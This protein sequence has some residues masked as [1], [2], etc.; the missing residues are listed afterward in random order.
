MPT[1][2][3][4]MVRNERHMAFAE[5]R[6]RAAKALLVG[7]ACFWNQAHGTPADDAEIR[8]N[9]AA[10]AS[11]EF[12]HREQATKALAAA[13]EAAIPFVVAAAK[14]GDREASYRALVVLDRLATSNE[15]GTRKA[16]RQALVELS[17]AND[18]QVAR[19]AREKLRTFEATAVARLRSSGA[20]V[21]FQDGRLWSVS[22]AN[23]PI[24]DATL[25]PLDDLEPGQLNLTRTKV[26]DETLARLAGQ[27]RLELLNLMATNVTDAGMPH[28]AGLTAMKTL[29][30]ER[31][32]VTD[33]GLEHL[34][35]FERLK[36][37]Y[38]GGSK[39]VGP[40]LEHVEHLPIEYLSFAF[41]QVDDSVVAHVVK[42]KGLKTLGLDDTEVT[43][44]CLPALAAL[45]NLEVLWLDNCAITDAGVPHIARLTG[46]KTLHVQHTR[47]SATGL[48]ELK[49]AL[50]GTRVNG[51]TAE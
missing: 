35:G 44:A 46:L 32:E 50:P 9:V 17:A 15:A 40:G 22:F 10:L 24:G 2:G 7:L 18:S 23:H 39:V 31:T 21:G 49:K 12:V 20:D 45:E 19:A 51:E 37:L 43:D 26:T 13:G 14:T 41:S 47:I 28:L 11:D 29:S 5:Q 25:A 4:S 36:I 38:L 33:A 3:E 30:V 8:R 16:A 6:F 1:D 27:K 48:A 34:R 42:L